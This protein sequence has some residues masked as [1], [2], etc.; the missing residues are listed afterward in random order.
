M[1][2]NTQNTTNMTLL[3]SVHLGG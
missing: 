2:I 1:L 3:M